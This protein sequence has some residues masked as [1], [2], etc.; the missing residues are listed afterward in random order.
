M[1]CSFLFSGF[2]AR[3]CL[4]DCVNERNEVTTQGPKS[5]I[6]Y[7]RLSNNRPIRAQLLWQRVEHVENGRNNNSKW[8]ESHQLCTG[9]V[10]GIL[11]PMNSSLLF[12]PSALFY[13]HSPCEPCVEQNTN[14]NVRKRFQFHSSFQSW[15]PVFNFVFKWLQKSHNRIEFHCHASIDSVFFL[16]VSSFIDGRSFDLRTWSG[17][18]TLLHFIWIRYLSTATSNQAYIW[19]GCEHVLRFFCCGYVMLT[20]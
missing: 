5:P 3:P 2:R 10:S 9:F 4:C 20:E 18:D 14:T 16:P 19:F 6:K 11:N 15:Q 17:L 1:R 8:T 12:L 13:E 7:A